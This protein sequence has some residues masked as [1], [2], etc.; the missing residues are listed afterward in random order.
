M[1][2][3]T[4]GRLREKLQ[5]ALNSADLTDFGEIEVKVGKM[6]YNGGTIFP[7]AVKIEVSKSGDTQEAVDFRALAQSYGLKAEDLGKIIVVSGMNLRITGL[8]TRARKRP[9]QLESDDGRGYKMPAA[10]VIR[11]LGD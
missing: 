1:S 6:T 8:N 7:V 5:D 9:I 2:K 3:E 11:L 10:D 4:L